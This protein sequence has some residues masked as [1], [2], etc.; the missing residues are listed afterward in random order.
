[1]NSTRKVLL[2]TLLVV[3]VLLLMHQLPTFSINGME[4][5]PVHLLSDLFPE[6]ETEE[7][8]EKP[9]S[10]VKKAPLPKY[11]P[12]GVELIEDFSGGHEGGMAHIYDRLLHADSLGTPIY[13]AYFGDSF[14]EGDIVTCDLREMLQE[15]Y[16]GNGPGWV[17]FGSISKNRPTARIYS[18]GLEE[19]VVIKKPYNRQL[20][21]INQRYFYPSNGATIRITPTKYKPHVGNWVNARLFLTTQANVTVESTTN[22]HESEVHTFAPSPEIQVTETKGTLNSISYR[23]PKGSSATRVF[24]VTLDGNYGVALDNFSMR[25]SAGY[26]IGDIPLSTLQGIGKY[27]PYDLIILQFGANVVD[28]NSTNAMCRHYIN[29]MKKVIA[30]LREAYPKASICVFSVPDRVQRS[31]SGIHT[32]KGIEKLVEFQRTMAAECG[33]AYLNVHQAMGGN[34]SMKSFVENGLAAKDY[35]HLNFKGGHAIAN[36]IYES[37]LAGVENHRRDLLNER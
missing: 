30:L 6:E 4:S 21:G 12:Q 14:I 16:G 15:K 19:N 25:G 10:P 9:V 2:L 34:D 28:N 33:V 5:R 20:G 17:D 24:G 11:H 8:A 27:R 1:M 35:T 22:G 29:R 3:S 31:A 13:I 36:H 26:T 37:I 32:I 23:F 18:Q 7:E